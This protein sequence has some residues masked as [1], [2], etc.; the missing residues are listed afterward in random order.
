MVY[1]RDISLQGVAQTTLVT[2]WY[3][4]SEALKDDGIIDDP[5]AIKVL[6]AMD[7]D[8]SGYFGKPDITTASRSRY[9]DG[10]VRDFL[11]DNPEAQVIALGEGLETQFWR[12]DNGKVRW[13]TVDLPETIKVR[14]RYFPAH[15]RNIPV[16][17]SALD[18]DWLEIIDRKRPVFIIITGLLMYLKCDQVLQLLRRISDYVDHGELFMDVVSPFVSWCTRFRLSLSKNFR[19]PHMPFGIRLCKV[20]AFVEQ[21]DGLKV[22]SVVSIVEADPK[23]H[24]DLGELLSTQFY[25][26]HFLQ[27]YIHASIGE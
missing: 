10:I 4:A 17:C 20:K 2:L 12:V 15:E 19:V 11:D 27:G 22:Q 21:I 23:S 3:R 14:E 26:D 5:V 8:F 25:R 7:Y 18:P 9:S 1:S 13:F 16:S 6:S 24:E